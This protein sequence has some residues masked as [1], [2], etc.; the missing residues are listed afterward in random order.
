MLIECCYSEIKLY[1]C[2]TQLVILIYIY[3]FP[4]GNRS[5]KIDSLFFMPYCFIL[6][7]LSFQ[8]DHFAVWEAVP[9]DSEADKGAF[10]MPSL[11]AGSTWIDME[12]V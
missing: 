12:E 6:P 3:H 4:N 5:V 1:L 9:V 10:L 2:I 8:S 11:D 7:S